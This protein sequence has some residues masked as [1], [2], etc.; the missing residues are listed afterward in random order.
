MLEKYSHIIYRFLK[1][2]QWIRTELFKPLIMGMTATLA[3]G[4]SI[5]DQKKT[6]LVTL[7]AEL[8]L[9]IHKLRHTH[10]NEL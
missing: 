5:I 7:L 3:E 1:K 9:K 8:L 2:T 10:Y 4:L 6:E